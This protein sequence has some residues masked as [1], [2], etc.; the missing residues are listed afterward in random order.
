[1][2]THPVFLYE[3]SR[4]SIPL[5]NGFSLI[6]VSVKSYQ[7]P[8]QIEQSK[9][10]HDCNTCE[11]CQKSKAGYIKLYR[12]IFEGNGKKLPFPMCCELHRKLVKYDGYKREDFDNTPEWTAD[13]IIFTVRHI[14]DYYAV[15]NWYK[16]ITDYIEHA[17]ESFGMMPEGCGNQ[18]LFPEY[19]ERITHALK[20]DKE[21]PA[22]KKR[23]ILDYLDSFLLKSDQAKNGTDINILITTYQKWLN[24]F[25][26]A[27]HS[28]FGE[29]KEHYQNNLPIF[30]REP[31][32]NMYSLKVRAPLHT[33][34][35]LI[36]M[37]V[38]LTKELLR[39]INARELVRLGIISNVELHRQELED[40]HLR[41]ASERITEVF[42]TGE[43]RYVTA[44]KEWLEAHCNYFHRFVPSS[45]EQKPES[46]KTKG[47]NLE[48]RLIEY[49][50]F[51][52]ASVQE[53]TEASRKKLLELLCNTEAPY[54]IAMFDFLG[55]LKHLDKQH[56][57]IKAK[58]H[59]E[60][61][62][63]F[64]MHHR[65][66]KGNINILNPSSTED[67]KKYTSYLHKET[68]QKD[69]QKLK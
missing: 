60:L 61:G 11:Q 48:A 38:E 31:E 50:F 28:Y 7:A 63:W 20:K 62:K 34:E 59:K 29:L 24:E 40:E 4:T 68:V 9:S 13:K 43:M 30:E 5:C 41:I 32:Q 45:N 66:I 18:F 14:T 44:L 69:Y 56:F 10:E 3:Q 35:S 64:E 15:D 6:Q 55:F 16:I 51:E 27:V 58:L 26:F 23:R 37:L 47:Q 1:M 25:P 33:Q 19:L 21:I 22:L 17:A 12:G 8:Y 54:R 49:G 2:K 57:P 42:S 52:L 65:A 53:L 67:K 39:K 36:E 46:I